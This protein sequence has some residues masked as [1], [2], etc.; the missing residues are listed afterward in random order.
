MTID[1]V[2]GRLKLSAFVLLFLSLCTFITLLLNP[3]IAIGYARQGLQLC[4][5][6]V[7]PSLF[8]FMVISGLFVELGVA[9]LLSKIFALPMRKLFGI[10]GAGSAAP[11][12]GALCGFPVGAAT[13]KRLY[14]SG[15]IGKGELVRLLT[16][17]NNPSSGFLISA[18]GNA[19]WSCPDFGVVLYVIQIFSAI[20]VG[21][22]F[23]FIMPEKDNFLNEKSSQTEFAGVRVF[24]KVISEAA[25][26]MLNVCALVLF[27]ASMV[28]ALLSLF[29]SFGSGQVLKTLVYGFFEMTGAC[30][31]AAKLLPKESGMIITALICGWSGL[32]VH[33]QVIAICHGERI[34]FAPYFAAKLLQGVLSAASMMVYI[35]LIDPSLPESCI[36]V[37]AAFDNSKKGSTEFAI[38]ANSVLVIGLIMK[39]LPSLLHRS[40]SHGRGQTR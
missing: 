24:Q 36:P 34:S 39:F 6:T 17:S 9:D 26:S 23:R 16:F 20:L 5:K 2:K 3:D 28:G 10:S 19:L 1:I 7:I 35:K 25:I 13:A 18:L 40:F 21:V 32:S 31:E 30:G 33:F 29:E 27:F 12:M 37:V 4:A 14:D 15:K 22:I 11:L 38:L 8:P